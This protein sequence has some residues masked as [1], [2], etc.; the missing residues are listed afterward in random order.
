MGKSPVWKG[1]RVAMFSQDVIAKATAAARSAG[2][3]PAA[4]LAVAEVESGS[5]VFAAVEGRQ[6]PLI[7]FEAH[8][9]D[10]RLDADKR[11]A[12]RAQGLA[13][14]AAGAVANP[15]TQAARWRM[16]RQAARIDAKAAYESTSWGLGQVMGAH[17][18]WL[19]Y[20]SV[21]AFVAE[22]RSG[23]GGQLRLMA[24]YIDK[25]GLFKALNTRDWATVARGY[26]GPGFRRND[27]DGKLARAYA[28]HAATFGKGSAVQPSAVLRRGARGAAV[29]AL[30]TALTARGHPLAADG[31]FG[32]ATER[33]VKA[34]QSRAGLA[35]DGIAG[36]ATMAA[37]GLGRSAE[38]SR[39]WLLSLF[40][41]LFVPRSG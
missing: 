25:A 7:R 19:G 15:A 36:P 17:W 33:A 4:L 29:A 8:Y 31:I 38:K 28:R 10:R 3:E 34:F 9:F 5:R 35:V 12:A 18:A 40:A 21:D 23:A 13:A 11:A 16:L 24:R 37:L 1:E 30:Q 14:A 2:L 22:A 20:A 39:N 6:E 26:N 27:Y 41:W 32:P